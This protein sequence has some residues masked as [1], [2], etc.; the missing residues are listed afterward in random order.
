MKT[1]LITGTST[2]IGRGIAEA[3]LKAGDQAV[4]TARN[5]H[6]MDDLVEQYGSRVLPL[7]L[8]VTDPEQR[9]E[10]VQRAVEKFGGIDVL[11][12]NAGR[13]HFG[14]VEDSPKDDIRLLF[15][16]NFFGPVGMIRDVLP[17]M[18]KAGSGMIINVSS[19]GVM[20]ENGTGNAYYT[21]SKAALEMLSDVLRNEVKPLGIDVMIIEPGTFRTEFRV[22]AIENPDASIADYEKTAGAS[23]K[24]LRDH[25]YNQSGDPAKAG[26]TIYTAVNAED[27]PE[28]LIL[29]KGMIE[30]AEKTLEDRIAEIKKWRDLSESTDFE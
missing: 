26:E 17:C 15:E 19:M 14:A 28:V 8:E 12:N 22:S 10:V 5:H 20:F 21:A 24:Y 4:V 25:P 18:R 1:W 6:K 7:N 2:G 9:R 29:G 16:T 13:G 30:A 11:V 27:K 3:V 23:R